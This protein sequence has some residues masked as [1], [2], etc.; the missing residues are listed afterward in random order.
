MFDQQQQEHP[1]QQDQRG[2]SQSAPGRR[3]L[4][5]W[6]RAPDRPAASGSARRRRSAGCPAGGPV[7][8][9]VLDK[10]EQQERPAVGQRQVPR[11]EAPNRVPKARR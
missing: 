6:R 5:T 10:F 7:D 2:V 4:G 3:P 1:Q 11:Q 9:Y 8:A